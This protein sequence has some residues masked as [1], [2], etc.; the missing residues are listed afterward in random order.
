MSSGIVKVKSRYHVYVTPRTGVTTYGAEIE[1]SDYILFSGIGKISKSIDATDYNVG[2]FV[3]ADLELKGQ[4]YNGFFND[5][6]DSRS[7]FKF[8]RDL[9]K[10]RV[11]YSNADGDTLQFRG[12]INEA[13]TTLDVNNNQVTFKVLSLDSVLRNTSIPAGVVSDGMSCKDAMVAIL[14]QPA[15]TAVLNVDP[16]NINPTFNFNIDVGSALDSVAVQDGMNQLL[17]CSNSVMLIDDEENLSIQSRVMTETKP[18]LNIFGPYDIYG[19]QNAVS[20]D[21]YNSGKQ[22]MFNSFMLNDVERQNFGAS[23]QYGF[24]QFQDTFDFLT[25]EG[26]LGNIAQELV[27]EFSI[28]KLEC[29]VEIP[30]SLAPD[31]QLL[32]AVSLNWPLLIKPWP[33]SFFPTIGITK[34]GDPIMPLPIRY[35]PIDISPNVAWKV[36]QVDDDPSKFIRTLKLRQAGTNISDGF[37]TVPGSSRVGFAIIGDGAIGDT[38]TTSY[39]PSIIGAAQVGNTM[40]A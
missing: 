22:R 28:P 13:A 18:L 11:I 14:T 36:I 3:F 30:V 9:A 16:S 39:N 23:Q 35:G 40:V 10:V 8:S 6:T 19:R 37:F 21:E 25:D 26:T 27:D 33:N 31:I 4:N 32:D 29:Q 7:I 24:N 38:G 15:I 12:L 2:I 34:I 17:V 20:L 1:V 5:E